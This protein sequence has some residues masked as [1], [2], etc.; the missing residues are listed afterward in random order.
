MSAVRFMFRLVS[1]PLVVSH[2][3]SHFIPM[4][5][6]TTTTNSLLSSSY[7]MFSAS[8]SQSDRKT[9]TTKKNNKYF[10]KGKL[11]AYNFFV[12]SRFAS[13]RREGK[14]PKEVFSFIAGLWR[15][16]T[17]EGK[18]SFEHN[19]TQ[20]AERYHQEEYDLLKSNRSHYYPPTPK[21][22]KSGYQHYISQG[23]SNR[24]DTDAVDMMRKLGSRWSSMDANARAPFQT[25]AEKDKERYKQ[26]MFEWELKH[27]PGPGCP[28]YD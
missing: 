23:F 10:P 3:N 14:N 5:T 27:I 2:T 16:L 19:A 7:R 28:P 13:V 15:E 11:S 24:G 20:D 26:E 21:K 9:K 22:N 8:S 4:I 18:S 6:T 12:K 25:L 17:P 1:S